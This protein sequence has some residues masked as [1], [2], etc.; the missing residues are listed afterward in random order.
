M[1]FV[2]KHKLFYYGAVMTYLAMFTCS[3]TGPIVA[4][5]TANPHSVSC[6]RSRRA[7]GVHRIVR[8]E[9]CECRS[10]ACASVGTRYAHRITCTHT[11]VDFMR[12]GVQSQHDWICVCDQAMI[13]AMKTGCI[14]SAA[15]APGLRSS[16]T[17]AGMAPVSEM[18]ANIIRNK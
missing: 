3:T 10:A 13:G 5:P 17:S 15:C 12:G 11:R 8:V 7:R 18:Y 14:H 9:A 16:S 6:T 1:P 4:N 2:S